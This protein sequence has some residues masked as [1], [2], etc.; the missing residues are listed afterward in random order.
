MKTGLSFSCIKNIL[1]LKIND[2][3]AMQLRDICNAISD[4]LD[5]ILDADRYCPSDAS[6]DIIRRFDAVS[7]IR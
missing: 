7:S 5:E 2:L 1:S 6:N 4:P 3:Q